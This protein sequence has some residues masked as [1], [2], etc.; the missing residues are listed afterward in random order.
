MKR[1]LPLFLIIATLGVSASAAIAARCPDILVRPDG[2]V[3][4]LAGT[5]SDG[6]CGY[7]C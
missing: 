7:Y 5:A 1:L 6:S 3:C 4:T 2:T